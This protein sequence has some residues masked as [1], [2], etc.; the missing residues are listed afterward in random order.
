MSTSTASELVQVSLPN[1]SLQ[2]TFL[3]LSSS[4]NDLILAVLREDGDQVL[5]DVCGIKLDGFERSIE[6]WGIQK[7]IRSKPNRIW[8]E[9][10][11]VALSTN[12]GELRASCTAILNPSIY[13]HATTDVFYTSGLLPLDLTLRDAL[14]YESVQPSAPPTPKRQFS[15]FVLTAHL[16][17]PVLRLVYLPQ[18][19]SISFVDIP[20]FSEG[21]FSRKFWIGAEMSAKEVM[22]AVVEELGIRLVILQGVKTA[23]VEY[24][25]HTQSSEGGRSLRRFWERSR[26]KHRCCLL[27]V[28]QPIPYSTKL[29]Y[30]LRSSS[31][32]LPFNVTFTV[33]S[34][35]LA[36]IGTVGHALTT[37]SSLLAKPRIGTRDATNEGS[38]RPSSIFAGIWA[39]PTTSDSI[40]EEGDGEDEEKE[41]T[42]KGL[43]SSEGGE[44]GTPRVSASSTLAS[45]KARLSTLFTDWMTVDDT[46]TGEPSSQSRIVSEPLSFVA[47]SSIEL[48]SQGLAYELPEDLE[49]SLEVLMVSLLTCL[50]TI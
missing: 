46:S 12:D 11:L 29:L 27:P 26:A 37:S 44:V 20:G 28:L 5:R 24:V 22:D 38:W 9:E 25:L 7:C 49:A 23:R 10:E 8:S 34:S 45:G 35:W 6:R 47:S 41:G 36:R 13:F 18:A 33:S 30:H 2:A 31:S 43:K 16:H 50:R 32:S 21:E 17:A 19:L 1:G 3:P 40:A 39:A 14:S 15:D 48:E 42:I 4:L